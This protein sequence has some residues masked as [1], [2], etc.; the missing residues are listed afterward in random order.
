MTELETNI[1]CA[2]KS[3]LSFA[4]QHTSIVD[5]QDKADSAQALLKQFL[6]LFEEQMKVGTCTRE[7]IQS[8]TLTEFHEFNQIA[9]LDYNILFWVAIQKY[10]DS[11]SD[12]CLEGINS[13]L[14]TVF[15]NA[16]IMNDDGPD[17]TDY[18]QLFL[19]RTALA[20]PLL[21]KAVYLSQNE[22]LIGLFKNYFQ[23][24]SSE[25][26]KG[27][28][29]P[30][31]VAKKDK[32][33]KSALKEF[34][35]KSKFTSDKVEKSVI[36]LQRSFRGKKRKKAELQRIKKLYSS[37]INS[38]K[39][40]TD[41]LFNEA[42]TPYVPL[43]C[44]KTLSERI[45]KAAAQIKLFTEIRHITNPKA[46]KS[47]LDDGIYGRETLEKFNM[48]YTP[49]ALGSGDVQDGDSNVVC[50]GPFDI[51][52]HYLDEKQIPLE[53]ILRSS[54]IHKNNPC[55][56]FKQRDL[57]YTKD[58]MRTVDLGKVKLNFTHKDLKG[59]NSIFYEF[60]LNEEKSS[61][62]I[63]KFMLVGY[64]VA[65]MHQVL[66]LN[67]FRVLDKISSSSLR[68]NI[69]ARIADLDDKQLA[70]WLKNIGMAFSDTAEFNFYG[71]HKINMYS[72]LKIK[73]K[74]VELN[75]PDLIVLLNRGD[76]KRLQE[77]I[78][79]IPS[80]FESYHFVTYLVEQV[81]HETTRKKL[82]MMKEKCQA[83]FY[84]EPA[85][86]KT[87]PLLM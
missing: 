58:H 67:F 60:S 57:H 84:K 36:T 13:N 79:K 39:K 6:A 10:V 81:S 63:P 82:M 46:L 54:Q 47:I 85:E 86:A 80:L 76:Q 14:E 16:R 50:F 20:N 72:L 29:V 9:W 52:T 70:S 4:Q 21:I 1:L 37:H 23:T 2:M 34:F 55:A 42:N 22:K 41:A 7:F 87:T 24:P 48:Q 51:D 15:S 5:D 64:D 8:A 18:H 32:E 43:Q 3:V 27:L 78:E 74:D 11:P 30:A 28:T 71:A 45:T 73:L 65:K 40:T 25:L 49:A 12:E 61:C 69:Y 44:N 68:N 75:I 83:P 66:I 33:K 77:A 62:L 31:E 35:A 19:M 59:D 26:F 56:F 38:S 17:E 53:I